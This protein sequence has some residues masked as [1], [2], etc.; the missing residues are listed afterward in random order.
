MPP[1]LSVVVV[2]YDSAAEL[3]GCLESIEPEVSA[4]WAEAILVDNASPDESTTVAMSVLPA[5]Q[6]LQLPKNR[7]FAAGVNAALPLAR[8]SYVLVLNPDVVVPERGLRNLV[9]WMDSHPGIAAASPE[10]YGP[11]GDWGTPGRALPAIWRL[12]LRTSRLY[13]LLPRRLAGNLLSGAFWPGGD[14]M[15][16]G[17][18]PATAIIVRTSA[19][20]AAGPLREDFFMYGEDVE[21]CWRIGRTAG[22][23]GVCA[24]VRFIHHASAAATR[25]WG[26]DERDRMIDAG[27]DRACQVIYGKRHAWAL[28]WATA[29]S[30]LVDARAPWR[31]ADERAVS[32]TAARRWLAIARSR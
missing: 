20:A 13:R 29:L 11:G 23:I 6:L 10:L 7:G 25:V 4:G 26:T 18:V 16:V 28:A 3:A 14:Q 22:R 21:W 27:L 15:G 9:A 1:S 32:A 24:G 19:V 30:L 2:L 5:A 17:W 31:S 12:A 8:G